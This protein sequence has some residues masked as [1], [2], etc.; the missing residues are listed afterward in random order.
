MHIFEFRALHP[1]HKIGNILHRAGT[2][3]RYKRNQFFKFRGMCRFQH[4][5]HA[6]GFKLEYGGGVG[7]AENLVS[8]LIVQR[9]AVHVNVFATRLADELLRHFDN[10]QVAQAQKVKF[11]QADFFHIAFVVHRNG[12]RMLVRLIHAA[13]IGNPPRRNQY[14]ARVHAQIACQIFQFQRQ[15]Q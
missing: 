1:R 15:R 11:N 13:E 3:Q 8:R 6:A 12:R 10:G 9:N 4:L 5:L 7:I 14:A 2:V